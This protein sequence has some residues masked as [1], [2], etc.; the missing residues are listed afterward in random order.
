MTIQDQIQKLK[1]EMEQNYND[2]MNDFLTHE[3]FHYVQDQ[4][5]NKIKKLEEQL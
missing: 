4:C 3:E 1:D 5:L 2:F